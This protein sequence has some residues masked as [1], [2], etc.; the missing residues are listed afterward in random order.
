MARV[1]TLMTVVTL[2]TMA[3]LGVGIGGCQTTESGEVA[4]ISNFS[5]ESNFEAGVSAFEKNDIPNA[6]VRAAAAYSQ[7]PKTKKYIALLA[8]TLLKQNKLSEAGGLLK[9]MN[10]IDPGYPETI[11]L[12][13]WLAY[14]E[15]DFAF[16][17]SKF[18]EEAVWADNHRR[19]PEYPR[20]YRASDVNFIGKIRADAANGLGLLALARG[21]NQ[22][23]RRFFEESLNASADYLGRSDVKAALAWLDNPQAAQTAA[24][25]QNCAAGRDVVWKN[26]QAGLY[27][28]ALAGFK[29]RI[30][31][32]C[33][34]KEESLLGQGVV[35]LALGH[36]DVAD[37][38]F[39]Q[40][41]AVNPNYVRAKVA[42]GA[43]A[44]S[45]KKYKEAINLYSAQLP[46]LPPSE[47]AW[48]WGSNAL[49]N[50]AWSYY[51][52]KDYK[53]AA[54]IF[55]KLAGYHERTTFA[56]PLTGQGWAA[57]R[58]DRKD[59]AREYFEKALKITPNYGL[60][61]QGFMESFR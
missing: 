32:N 27:S 4:A 60:A 56:A 14:M 33:P 28:Q 36:Y 46:N 40:A 39:Y 3:G 51:F 47:E 9:E 35:E 34:Q 13:A 25:E 53:N 44:Y 8:W 59:E 22:T 29:E 57:L 21:D 43:V 17:E 37:K 54:V 15:K 1:R 45:Q 19:R 61:K 20:R 52:T 26:F 16:A 24:L 48:E 23:A 55:E 18:K 38:L 58:M 49:N 2:A 6:H 7:S 41:E 42:H 31:I 30:S 12:A 10:E 5:A 50:L 11:Q